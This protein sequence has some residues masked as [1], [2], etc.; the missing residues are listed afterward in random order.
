MKVLMLTSTGDLEGQRAV[1]ERAGVRVDTVR[2]LREVLE[3]VAR[4]SYRV[5][6]IDL[7]ELAAAP[8]EVVS[9]IRR[10]TCA[11]LLL[12]RRFI[13]DVD[14]IVALEAGADCIAS[15]PFTGR[16]LLAHLIAIDRSRGRTAPAVDRPNEYGELRVDPARQSVWW[17]NSQID[18]RGLELDILNVLVAARGR[19]VARDVILERLGRSNSSWRATNTAVSR[20][21]NRLRA[22][23]VDGIRI[24]AI[25]GYGY[26]LSLCDSVSA[27]GVLN[28]RSLPVPTVSTDLNRQGRNSV[29]PGSS[30][31]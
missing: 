22:Q 13:D 6:A 16:L 17:N 2:T 1:L 30:R 11:P 27:I 15:K 24:C 20:L 25:S 3:R 12:T 19:P 31:G 10:V 23:G 18:L 4:Y 8:S 29:A 14:Q 9:T 26:R 21:R 28:A 5:I 7:D